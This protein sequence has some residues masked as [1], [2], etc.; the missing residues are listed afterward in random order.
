MIKNEE[1]KDIVDQATVNDLIDHALAN[2]VNYFDS[3]PVYLQ[4]QCEAATGEAL[5][6]HPRESYFVATKLSNFKN[7]DREFGLEMYRKSLEAFRTDYLDYYLLHSISGAEAFNKRFLDN[8]LIDFLLEERKAGRI[9]NL[10]FSFHGSKEGFD[11]LMALHEK[12]H[13]D[14]VQIQLNYIDWNYASKRN[15]NASYLQEELDKR[16]IPSIIMEPLLGGR[17]ADAPDRIADRLKE[18]NPKGTIASWAFRFAGSHEGVLTVLS[19]MNCMEHLQDNLQTYSPL[20]PLT[21]KEMNFLEEIARMRQEYPEI[22]CTGCQYCM[23]CPYGID[24]P[25]IFT[26]YNKCVN[27]G[28]INDNKEDDQYAKDRRTYLISYDRA[29]PRLRQADRCAACGICA[30]KCPQQINIPG[31]LRRIDRLVETLKSSR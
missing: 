31:E 11:E 18:M 6:R 27:E 3:A 1:G 8:G 29:I 2:G 23:P 7:T 14:F 25:S 24:I 16:G 26:H 15:T 17:L 4:G 21:E 20:V 28:F 19:G 22:T 5:S 30:I 12:Y 9:K 10:G 13:W